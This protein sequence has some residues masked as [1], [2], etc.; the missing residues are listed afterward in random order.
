MDTIRD[1][2]ELLYNAYE[3]FSSVQ[4]TVRTWYD[5]VR[6]REGWERWAAQEPPGSVAFLEALEA[7]GATS[8]RL[9]PAI[10]E[11]IERLWLHKPSRC[12]YESGL[13]GGRRDEIISG[14]RLDQISSPPESP[15]SRIAEMLDPAPLIPFLWLQPLGRAAYA[16]REAIRV[17]GLPRRKLVDGIAP[18]LLWLGASEYN[19]LVDAERGV[20]LRATASMDD[21]EFAG[22]EFVHV[23]FDEAIP[24]S[25]FTFARPE[26]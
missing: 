24:D 17:R 22:S 18:A 20:L 13:A 2:L 5:V 25:V 8:A 4:V 6:Q 10:I 1:V 12:R 11:W 19:L 15:G 7:D 14:D 21:E 9:D 23:V 3:R 26:E 16:G